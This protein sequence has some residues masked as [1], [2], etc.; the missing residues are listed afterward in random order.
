MTFRLWQLTPDAFL[1]W[2]VSEDD[3]EPQSHRLQVSSTH[4]RM[5][6]L[7][8]FCTFHSNCYVDAITT[9]RLVPCERLLFNHWANDASF[10]FIR[11][12]KRRHISSPETESVTISIEATIFDC[13]GLSHV[14]RVCL[15]NIAHRISLVF[16]FF[17]QP[18]DRKINFTCEQKFHTQ[19]RPALKWKTAEFFFA[20]F[21]EY[22]L[23]FFAIK[24]RRE[25]V[26]SRSFNEN[27]SEIRKAFFLYANPCNLSPL[28]VFLRKPLAELWHFSGAW[29]TLNVVK[30]I[31]DLKSLF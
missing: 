15:I 17:A 12:L 8:F 27:K 13:T 20:G 24:N 10:P 28:S 16:V 19:W 5:L 4:V 18:E 25:I 21:D 9:P 7:K 1:R 29:P 26:V 30:D 14:C 2:A 31:F 23:A 11:S 3:V 22:I 6:L